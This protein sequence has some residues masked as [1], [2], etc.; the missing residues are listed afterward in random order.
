V[1]HRI[2]L[3]CVGLVFGGTL[4]AQQRPISGKVTGSLDGK[5]VAGASVAVVGTARLAATNASGEYTVLA[6]AGPVTLSVRA[7]GY[8]RPASS[9]ATSP[10][11]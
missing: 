10:T 2:V 6:P 3:V 5:P 7:V 9:N 11:P 8:K 1:A 4:T